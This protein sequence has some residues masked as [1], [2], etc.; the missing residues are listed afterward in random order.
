MPSFLRFSWQLGMDLWFNCGLNQSLIQSVWNVIGSQ[1]IRIAFNGCG[2]WRFS[3]VVIQLPVM[4][5][6]TVQSV[7]KRQW[8]PAEGNWFGR[9]KRNRHNLQLNLVCWLFLIHPLQRH[10]EE[11]ES[12]AGT[13]AIWT[14]QWVLSSFILILLILIIT[15]RTCELSCW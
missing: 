2:E 11:Q 4:Q 14:F 13:L 6:S 1:Y 10:V 5:L 15:P 7:N 12:R 8:Q 9:F 3:H